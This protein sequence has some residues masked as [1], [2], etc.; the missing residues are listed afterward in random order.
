M[1]ITGFDNTETGVHNIPPLASI[2]GNI[3]EMATQAVK[4]LK[5]RM[6]KPNR[7]AREIIVRSTLIQRGSHSHASL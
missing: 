7:V 4:L 3:E 2:D 1:S 6:T 5:G